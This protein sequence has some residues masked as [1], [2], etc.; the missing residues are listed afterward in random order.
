MSYEIRANYEEQ[1]LLPPSLED[2]IPADHPARFIRD[3]IDTMDLTGLGFRIREADTGRPNYS[4]DLLLKVWLY[5]YL[6]KIR[7]SRGLEKACLNQMPL[8]WLTGNHAPDHNTLW[9][10][11]RDNQKALQQVFRQ[12]VQVAWKANLVG[13][14]L[15]A[16]DGTKITSAGSKSKAV[17]KED[18]EQ[19]LEELDRSIAE[20]S[21]EV[22]A[23]ESEQSEEYRLPEELTEA[24]E[25][26][27]APTGH[28]PASAD[29]AKR[30]EAEVVI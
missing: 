20:M 19:L 7:S 14:V 22:E 28:R 2:W 15:H 18:L 1:Y 29:D 23:R 4:A 21:K 11:W 6:E 27:E 12:S 17:H 26:P 3:F 24:G 5:G 30:R 8:I 13:L 10:F 25:R 16:V 9:R